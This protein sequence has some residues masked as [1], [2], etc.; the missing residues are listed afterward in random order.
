MSEAKR[1]NSRRAEYRV[2]QDEVEKKL[3]E[4]Y[5]KRMVYDQ[6]VAAGR[7]VMSY[8]SFCDYARG[9]GERLHRD[10]AGCAEPGPALCAGQ[11]DERTNYPI[12]PMNLSAS[13]GEGWMLAMVWIKP[14]E[15]E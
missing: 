1:V 3:D 2:I 12:V 14:L 4:G 5:S 8:S 9:R 15:V 6:L 11:A 13:P 7:L 10:E